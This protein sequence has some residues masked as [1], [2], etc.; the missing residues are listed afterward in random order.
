MHIYATDEHVGFIENAIRHVKERVRCVCHGAPYQKY[1]RLMT[2][3]V[4]EGTI[5]LINIFPTGN[6][7]SVDMSPAMIV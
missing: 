4:V 2:T 6:G 1:T 3:S 5:D 7:I